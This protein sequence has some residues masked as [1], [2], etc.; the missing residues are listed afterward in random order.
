MLMVFY[1]WR[2]DCDIS[3]LGQTSPPHLPLALDLSRL[4]AFA[5]DLAESRCFQRR[6]A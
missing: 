6:G 2:I 5:H 3:V 4:K 1:D